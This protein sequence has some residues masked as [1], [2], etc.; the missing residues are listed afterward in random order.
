MHTRKLLL[1]SSLFLSLNACLMAESSEQVDVDPAPVEQP[2]EGS[3]PC[4]ER[5]CDLPHHVCKVSLGGVARCEC[6]DLSYP[7]VQNGVLECVVG[8][9]CRPLD[10]QSLCKNEGRCLGVFSNDGVRPE[11][12]YGDGY[13]GIEDGWRGA[14]CSV[15]QCSPGS[16]G[17]ACTPPCQ[18]YKMMCGIS[19]MVAC[20]FGPDGEIR[21]PCESP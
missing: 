13:L 11:C 8:E 5:V 3:D 18:A 12:V 7:I 14:D 10:R 1:F 2:I 6:D 9:A 15:P 19:D 4:Q 20:G 16:T 21:P 17:P